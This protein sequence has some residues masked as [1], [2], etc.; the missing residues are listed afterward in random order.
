MVNQTVREGKS[1]VFKQE[2][3]YPN[4]THDLS[5]SLQKFEVLL[6]NLYSALLGWARGKG[7]TPFVW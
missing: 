5:C 6:Q 3:V 7:Y 4:E 2:L 1:G